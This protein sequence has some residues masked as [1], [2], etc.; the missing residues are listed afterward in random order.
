MRIE[1]GY[2]DVGSKGSRISVVKIT[3]LT[4]TSFRKRILRYIQSS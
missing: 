2:Y 1:D 3:V 4:Y